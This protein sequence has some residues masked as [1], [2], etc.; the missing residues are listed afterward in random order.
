[1]AVAHVQKTPDPP[2]TRTELP[3]P[4]D[5]E[6]VVLQCLAKRPEDRPASAA[7]LVQLLDACRD[8]GEWT[9]TDA[10]AWWQTHLPPSSTFRRA[11]LEPAAAPSPVEV[12]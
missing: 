7:H 3:V 11:T 1:M 2:S 8:A 12:R 10:E 6:R 4:A 9:E 5:L